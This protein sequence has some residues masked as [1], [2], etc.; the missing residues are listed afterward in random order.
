MKRVICFLMVFILLSATACR[1]RTATESDTDNLFPVVNRV[2]N[3]GKYVVSD[4]EKIYI[5]HKSTIYTLD[6]E[7]IPLVTIENGYINRIIFMH[8]KIYFTTLEK[9]Y[10]VNTDGSGLKE[11]ISM[12]FPDGSIKWLDAEAVGSNIY[13]FSDSHSATRSELMF[14]DDGTYDVKTVEYIHKYINGREM[15]YRYIPA[16]GCGGNITMT[17]SNG[18][19]ITI[20]TVHHRDMAIVTDDYIF[21]LIGELNDGTNDISLYRWSLTADESVGIT[22]IPSN[23]SFIEFAGYDENNVY[24]RDT[25]NGRY[26]GYNQATGEKVTADIKYQPGVHTDICD[27]W[28]YYITVNQPYRENLITGEI[29][30]LLTE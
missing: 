10:V 16:Y 26:Y 12:L 29:Q 24:I 11:V 5:G 15:V 8:G 18:D 13:L 3:R 7:M 23:A 20:V 27:G 19:D 28:L 1:M 9:M 14:N 21:I 22:S 2:N 4:G 17:G 6:D 30:Y 25:Y